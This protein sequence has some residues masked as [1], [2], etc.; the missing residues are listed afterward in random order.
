MVAA[1]KQQTA[2]QAK[3]RSNAS[4]TLAD[5]YGLGLMTLDIAGVDKSEIYAYLSPAAKKLAKTFTLRQ[6]TKK[7]SADAVK[8][9]AAAKR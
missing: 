8:R 6:A 7:K 3:P 9:R 4:L 2:G 1:K 5:T